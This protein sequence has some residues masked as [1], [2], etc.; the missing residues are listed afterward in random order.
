MIVNLVTKIDTGNQL[1]VNT[2]KADTSPT[3]HHKSQDESW[4]DWYTNSSKTD[5]PLYIILVK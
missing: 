5:R 4:F 2:E 1:T 3:K